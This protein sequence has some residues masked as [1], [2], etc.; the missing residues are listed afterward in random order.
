M[1]RKS[2]SRHQRFIMLL[3]AARRQEHIND[4]IVEKKKGIARIGE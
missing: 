1:N 4:S 3:S 2:D